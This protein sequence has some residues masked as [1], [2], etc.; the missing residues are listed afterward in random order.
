MLIVLTLSFIVH[1][2]TGKVVIGKDIKGDEVAVIKYELEPIPLIQIVL[3]LASILSGYVSY[4][5]R[6]STVPSKSRVNA[7]AVMKIVKERE[8]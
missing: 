6:I 5:W 7:R 8:V 1:T 2:A 4:R 3:T